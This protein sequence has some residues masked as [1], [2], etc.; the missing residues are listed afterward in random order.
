MEQPRVGRRLLLEHLDAALPY[1][2][3]HLAGDEGCEHD[4][5]EGANLLPENGHREAC[6]RHGEPSFFVELLNLD[7]A[8]LS[9]A[10]PLEAVHAGAIDKEDEVY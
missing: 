1:P 3:P 7:G 10:Y 8:E 5:E 4:Q 9:K 6:L 2:A